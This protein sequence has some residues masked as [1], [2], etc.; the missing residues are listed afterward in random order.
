[1][2]SRIWSNL[3][4]FWQAASAFI[5]QPL[6]LPPHRSLRFLHDITATSP[7]TPH[8]DR[9]RLIPLMVSMLYV[10]VEIDV[11]GRSVSVRPTAPFGF[12]P[13]LKLFWFNLAWVRI[14][15][16]SGSAHLRERNNGIFL[17]IFLSLSR[18]F[19]KVFSG[20][21]SRF[22]SGSSRD[23]ARDHSRSFPA[24]T[25]L[26][27]NKKTTTFKKRPPGRGDADF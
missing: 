12:R 6:L 20:S 1:M 7:S 19:L 11:Y 24:D 10:W 5:P 17:R 21:F 16:Y 14:G 3:I 8:P 4:F 13:P 9:R 26:V 2:R 25:P 15:S 22:L 23:L 18:S 27:V